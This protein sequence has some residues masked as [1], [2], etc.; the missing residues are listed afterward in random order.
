MRLFEGLG[1]AKHFA[2]AHSYY[3]DV[4]GPQATVAYTN[5]G[6]DIAAAVQK[7]N[8]FGCQF[9]PEKSA[10]G[11]LNILRNF[12]RICKEAS[13]QNANEKSHPLP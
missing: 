6:I 3:A 8:I 12:E 7:R 1:G 5:Y 11:G 9:H 4:T 2:F 10:G 13:G